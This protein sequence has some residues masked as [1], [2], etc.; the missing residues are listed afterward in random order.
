[1][2]TDIREKAERLLDQVSGAMFHDGASPETVADLISQALLEAHKAGREEMREEAAKRADFQA[3]WAK[4]YYSGEG[5]SE[6]CRRIASAI[7][8]LP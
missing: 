8:S 2:T 7:R 6:M 4:P 5:A 1:M 3:A